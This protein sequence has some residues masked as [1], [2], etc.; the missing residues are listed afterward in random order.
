[1][2]HGIV[3]DAATLAVSPTHLWLVLTG[4]RK[5]AA[6]FQRYQA[7]KSKSTN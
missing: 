3:A 4:Q 7:L 1:V 5:S 2:F 6:L